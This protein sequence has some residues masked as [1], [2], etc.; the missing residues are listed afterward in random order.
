MPDFSGICPN[1][2]QVR[3]LNEDNRDYR[4]A[5]GSTINSDEPKV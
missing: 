3:R 1:G 2:G 4:K 5:V